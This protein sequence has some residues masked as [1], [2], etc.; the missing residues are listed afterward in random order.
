[1]FILSFKMLVKP[2]QKLFPVAFSEWLICC[3]RR[4][5]NFNSPLLLNK[6]INMKYT[7]HISET[8]GLAELLADL[9]CGDTGQDGRASLTHQ[10]GVLKDVIYERSR[11]IGK[12]F[13][14]WVAKVV[15]V[16]IGGIPSQAGKQL[17]ALKQVVHQVGRQLSNT[18]VL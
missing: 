17:A 14:A 10:V 18:L 6:G 11:S 5:S 13:S 12:L 3:P 8:I 7:I 2:E 16:L 15:A 1:M 9:G 4:C